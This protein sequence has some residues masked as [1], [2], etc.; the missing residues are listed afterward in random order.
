MGNVAAS[1]SPSE[2]VPIVPTRDSLYKGSKD[3]TT[4]V[5]TTPAC[6]TARGT[7]AVGADIIHASAVRTDDS[8]SY[9]PSS[10]S[11][12]TTEGLPSPAEPV[13]TTSPW[14]YSWTSADASEAADSFVAIIPDQ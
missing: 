9:A 2:R 4:Q 8:H 3:G 13:M 14:A 11:S 7:N 1:R 10:A 5:R 6:Q 12:S